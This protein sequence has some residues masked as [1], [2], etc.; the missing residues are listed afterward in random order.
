MLRDLCKEAG[1]SDLEEQCQ[2]ALKEEQEHLEKVR[3]WL[4]TMTLNELN[5]RLS[6]IEFEDDEKV[7]VASKPAEVNAL[8]LLRQ[9]HGKVKELFEEAEGVEEQKQNQLFRKIKKETGNARAHRGDGLLP[10]YATIR[11]TKRHGS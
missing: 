11:R 7:A 3:V 4:S 10:R 9:D 8:E 6:N 1:Y 5:G 2:K